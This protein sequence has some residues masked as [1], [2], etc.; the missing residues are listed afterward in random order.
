MQYPSNQSTNPALASFDISDY[1]G[2]R[3][4]NFYEEDRVL[5]TVVEKY[6]EGYDAAHKKA[7][8]DHLSGY[9]SLVG[10]IL[11]ELTDA[12]HKE[13]KYGEIVKYDRT[14]NRID[15]VVYSNEQKLSRKISYD[16]GIVNLNYHSSWK[17]PFTDLHRYA[18]TYLSNQNGEGG[19]T[20]PLAMTEGMIKVLE[21]L[22]TPEQKD[23]F[24]TMVAGEGSSSHFMAGQYV[25]E[26]V[27]GSNVSANRT[28]AR[29]RENGK[30]ILTGEKWFCSNPGDVWVTT[31]RVEDSS[32]IGLFLVPRIKDDGTLNGHHILRKKDIIGSRGKLTVEIVYDGVEAEALGRPAHGIANLIKYVIGISRLHVSLAASGISRRAWMEAYEY[33]K[34]RTAYGSKILEFSSL[35]K[36]LSDQRLK[37]TAMLASVFR[38]IHTPDSLKLAGEVLAPLLKYKCSSTSTEITYNSILVLGGNGIVGDFSAL[39]RLHNDSIINETWEGTHLLLSEHVLRGFKREKVAKAFFQYTEDITD[40]ESPAAETIRKKSKLLREILANSDAEALD[41]NRIY[42]SDLAFEIFALASLSD[43]SGKK[44]PSPQKDLSLFRDGYL[45][46]IDTGGGFADKSRFSGDSERLK[47]VIHY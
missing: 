41:L 38:H 33:A 15:Q 7:M 1:K 11:D 19:V 5:Q 23:K 12:S 4:K 44:A 21:A 34:F 18:L 25:T 32:T 24:L 37:H 39:P 8:I 22:G 10:G 6:S 29:K 3:G 40:F 14:G 30:W 36:Q 16:Y 46:L 42:I 27:G 20:C 2:N 47:S 9:G 31:A 13:G 45:D 28:I 35:L 17:H 43:L 26:R